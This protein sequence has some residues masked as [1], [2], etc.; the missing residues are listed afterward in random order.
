[1]LNELGQNIN[2]SLFNSCKFELLF[3]ANY[4]QN[5]DS[6]FKLY[7]TLYNIIKHKLNTKILLNL[8]KIYDN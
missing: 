8:R 3:R 2:E 5:N 7:N 1:M 4:N 6:E